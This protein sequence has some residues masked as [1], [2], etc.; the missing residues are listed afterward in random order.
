MIQFRYYQADIIEK[1]LQAINNGYTKILIVLAAGAGKTL[2]YGGILQYLRSSSCLI[3]VPFTELKTQVEEELIN[4]GVQAEVATIQSIVAGDPKEVDLFIYDEFHH[5]GSP[6]HGEYALDLIKA[7]VLIGVTATPYRVDNKPLLWKNG[8]P[9]EIVIMGP[10]ISELTDNNFLAHLEYFSYPLKESVEYQPVYHYGKKV[11]DVRKFHFDIDDREPRMVDEYVDH[12]NGMKAFC[13]CNGIKHAEEVSARFN[14]YGIT[15]AYLHCHQSKP[16][17]EAALDGFKNG[18][19][20]ILT[21]VNLLS[22]GTNIP[23]VKLALLARPISKSISLYAQQ[24]WRT[25]RFYKDETAK[26]LDLVGNVYRFGLVED[27]Y[28]KELV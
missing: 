16:D 23:S 11:C 26:V 22:E 19:T 25:T 14:S 18:D 4:L 20:K 15:A 5:A 21:A 10:D 17:R 6:M 7:K 12:F 13:F 1:T 2:T 24:I 3:A 27:I 28:N 8:G 9:A